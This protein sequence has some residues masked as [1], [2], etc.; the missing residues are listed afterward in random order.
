IDDDRVVGYVAVKVKNNR[1][2]VFDW[3]ASDDI[4]AGEVA[5]LFQQEALER[6]CGR[7][8]LALNETGA[9]ADAFRKA[10]YIRRE[11]YTILAR[12]LDESCRTALYGIP[13]QLSMADEDLKFVR[14]F[15]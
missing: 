1:L 11:Q 4:A 15:E 6:G 5:S 2:Y 13:W 10:G 8:Y 14:P 3:Q 7:V 12:L 9:T